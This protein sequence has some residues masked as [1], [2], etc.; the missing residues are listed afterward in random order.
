MNTKTTDSPTIPILDP[1]SISRL[2]LYSANYQR[3]LNEVKSHITFLGSF[4]S[5]ESIR[6]EINEHIDKLINASDYGI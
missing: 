6:D 1:T 3:N 2:D 5:Y 4:T